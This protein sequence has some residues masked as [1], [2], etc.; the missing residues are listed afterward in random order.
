MHSPVIMSIKLVNTISDYIS[1][2]FRMKVEV[3]HG[4]ACIRTDKNCN[5]P[6]SSEHSMQHLMVKC[7][8]IHHN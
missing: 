6:R 5:S 4:P 7:F 8:T 3:A 2:N 1:F